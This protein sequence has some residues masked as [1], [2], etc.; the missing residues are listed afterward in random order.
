MDLPKYPAILTPDDHD[1]KYWAAL[2][3]SDHASIQYGEDDKTEVISRHY[4]HNGYHD[5]HYKDEDDSEKLGLRDVIHSVGTFLNIIQTFPKLAGRGRD[6][7]KFATEVGLS[8]AFE[9]V[10]EDPNSFLFPGENSEEVHNSS[11]TFIKTAQL[12]PTT[13]L[14]PPLAITHPPVN[15]QED[16]DPWIMLSQVNALFFAKVSSSMISPQVAK[17]LRL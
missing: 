14:M 5:F 13:N 6:Q 16:D 12:T 17:K 8:P 9:V 7:Q 2:P 4:H 1:D 11:S 3:N 10:S 15:S